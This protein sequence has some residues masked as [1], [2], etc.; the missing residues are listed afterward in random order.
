MLIQVNRDNRLY[1]LFINRLRHPYELC[2][3]LIVSML[4]PKDKKQGLSERR[5]G[6]LRQFF[7]IS[8]ALRR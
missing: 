5:S 7:Q 6:R 1:E 4:N 3:M 8:P 2:P